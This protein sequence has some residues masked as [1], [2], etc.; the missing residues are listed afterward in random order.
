M[1][2]HL[3][4]IIASIIICAL[5]LI[6]CGGGGGGGG[7]TSTPSEPT[8][9]IY[10]TEANNKG[11]FRLTSNKSGAIIESSEEGTLATGSSIV[12]TERLAKSNESKLYGGNSSNIYTLQA[13]NGNKTIKKLDKPVILTIPN[14]FGK[15][16]K[17]FFLG[18]KSETASDWQ[19]T[20]ILDD[21]DTNPTIV[22]TA[23][24]AVKDLST[25]KVKTFRL[26]YSF[27]IFASKDS[28][29]NKLTNADSV[30]LMTFSA[31]PAKVYYD[32][33]NKYI[34]DIKVSSC[35]T[36]NKSSA[37]FDGSEVTSQ[38]VFFNSNSVDLSGLKIDGSAAVQTSSTDKDSSNNQY[39][40]TIYIKSYKKNNTA[41]SGNNA[42]Y[43]FELKLSGISTKD[44]PDSFRVKTVLKDANGTEF[45]SEGS[46]KL[47]KEKEP[48]KTNTNTSTS[49]STSTNT[50]TST[51]TSTNTKT[52]T[53]TG[54][55]TK[56]S[57]AT[58]TNTKT[59]TSTD[60]GSNTTTQT[61][62]STGSETSSDTNT[63]SST[64]TG[65]STSTTT[66]SD[67]NTSSNTQTTT[68]TDT[69]TGS[70]TS[71]ETNTQTSTN[72]D[73]NS[74]TDTSTSTG[75]GT[76][77]ITQATAEI[78][79]SNDDIFNDLYVTQPTFE[80]TIKEKSNYSEN[81]VSNA[82][83][84]KLGDTD[85][86][87]NKTWNNGKLNIAFDDGVLNVNET[88]KI[89]IN[90]AKDNEN[91]D[92][93]SFNE[94]SFTTLPFR[95]KGTN[96]SPFVLDDAVSP[97]L[98]DSEGNMLLVASLSINV[99]SIKDSLG[100]SV[101]LPSTCN[102]ATGT[103]SNTKW[104]NQQAVFDSQNKKLL[105]SIPENL[106]W[107]ANSQ[108]GI[109]ANFT[110]R[111]KSKTIYFKTS[112][113]N[114]T[115]ETG[116]NWFV[117]EGTVDNPYWVYT[118]AQLDNIRNNLN[119][120]YKM[121][122]DINI[123]TDYYVSNTNTLENGWTAIGLG[124]VQSTFFGNL[125]GNNKII[126]G[127][128]SNK[129]LFFQNSESLSNE[130][131]GIINLI[132]AT[133]CAVISDSLNIGSV[134]ASN[135]GKISN[136]SNYGSVISN[137]STSSYAG[138]ICGAM[139]ASETTGLITNCSNYGIV[140]GRSIVGGIVGFNYGGVIKNC[141]N[142]GEITGTNQQVGGICGQSGPG[143]KGE[144]LIIESCCNTGNIIG[145]KYSLGG[146]VGNS[147]GGDIDNCCN[148]GAVTGSL[149]ES[150]LIGGI[151]GNC[152][153]TTASIIGNCYSI[154]NF[155]GN[156]SVDTNSIAG[157][158]SNHVT[159]VVNCFSAKATL[160]N[161]SETTSNKLFYS[162]NDIGINNYV[163]ENGYSSEIQSVQWSSGV[164]ACGNTWTDSRYWI[165]SSNAL[166]KLVNCGANHNN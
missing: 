161:G 58:S 159:A 121:M 29:E 93:I 87:V 98:T 94:F 166:P 95:G 152:G 34:T 68:N 64:D 90:G 119:S 126:S 110:G 11:S 150:G 15:E 56:T 78:T 73:T 74:N 106:L 81:V 72:T 158:C 82:V 49:T 45:A 20:Q 162:T 128:R 101:E 138:G 9:F 131:Y 66:S 41:I 147:S 13:K 149:E 43:T 120:T 50:K 165:L 123:S 17:T 108:L 28:I 122:R 27:A 155:T 88:Y 26:S 135:K 163:F 91:I 154:G 144:Y 69:N 60:T 12:L 141:F 5:L 142:A 37:L 51:G 116:T 77:T 14:N 59:N 104:N 118:P 140:Q 132:I 8:E 124:G 33:N 107:Q 111:Y 42:T 23:R 137:S 54:T 112:E 16:F 133:D 31:D 24:L 10:S 105:V 46:V 129:G 143:Y 151:V 32:K 57:T 70:G 44:F 67:T 83:S 136:C 96:S 1:K 18:S 2:K 39:S 157:S 130:D 97:M 160:I 127:M 19:Y 3:L 48:E 84:V 4:S 36:A 103:A 153:G 38:L 156:T 30:K 76:G 71:T 40:H 148:T 80:I 109:T 146:I 89:S 61:T 85:V 139:N 55:S 22:K 113:Q 125:D 7:G 134:V 62:T 145:G 115:T 75:T 47:K 102:I 79:T 92:I 114:I 99:S 21:N 65:S 86:S 6:G 52:S 53:S 117:G 100:N 35:I 63:A 164:S 25:F